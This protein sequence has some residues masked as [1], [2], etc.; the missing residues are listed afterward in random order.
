MILKHFLNSGYFNSEPDFGALFLNYFGYS[1]E[2]NMDH[3]FENIDLYDLYVHYMNMLVCDKTKT[4][5]KKFTDIQSK[6]KRTTNKLY[7]YL[8]V[9]LPKTNCSFNFSYLSRPPFISEIKLGT[10]KFVR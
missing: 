9:L 1:N 2:K 6:V 8:I 10:R 5:E 4:G 7:Y 3:F